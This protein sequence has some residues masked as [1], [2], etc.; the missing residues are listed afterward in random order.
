MKIAIIALLAALAG[1]TTLP[2]QAA[3]TSKEI[4]QPTDAVGTIRGTII[5]ETNGE[6]LIGVN[7]LVEGSATGTITDLD[8][9]FTLRLKPGAYNLNISYISYAS[10]TISEIMLS[11]DQVQV[12]DIRMK[13][14]TQL[15]S[16]V[17]VSARA[18]RNNE[19][20]LLTIQKKS[21]NLL[22]GISAQTFSRT[23]DSDV[24]S[25]VKRVTGV[26]VEDGKYVY[27]RGL[28]DR[29]SKSILNGMEIP[30]LDPER[31]T[32][33]LDIFPTN[34]IDNIIVYKSFTP[35]LPGDFTGGMVN[36]ETKDFPESRSI[37]IGASLGYDTETHFRDAFILYDGSKADA[38]A[39]GKK[40]RAL[41]FS[42]DYSPNRTDAATL[43]ANTN[44]LNKELD[45]AQK[46]NFLDQSYS[47]SAGN[48]I[49][50]GQARWGYFTALNY[51]NAYTFRPDVIRSE[52]RVVSSNNEAG[53][54]F[55]PLTE[56]SG[57]VGIQEVLWSAMASASVKKNN[58]S[59]SLKLFHT[60]SG[61]K[62]AAFYN[63]NDL[64]NTQ[65]AIESDLGYEQRMISNAL[66]SGEHL[67]AKK[68][69]LS[70]ANAFTYTSIDEPELNSS[71]FVIFDGDTLFSSGSSNVDK[72][73]R[74]LSEINNNTKFDYEM[75]FDSW[76]GGGAKFKAGASA[77]FKSRDYETYTVSIG[78]SD[79]FSPELTT[80][81]GGLNTILE[82]DNLYS[83]D[84][85]TGYLISNVQTDRENQY[86]SQLT[87]T[88]LYAMVELPLAAK[89]KFIGGLR[90]EYARM[91]YAGTERLS[92]QEIDQNVLNSWQ[93][94][95]AA[96]FVVNITDDMNLKSSYSRTLA[97]PSFREKSESI[98][99]DPVEGTT[100]YG[101]LNLVET[102]IHNA[103]LRWEYFF[104]RGEMVSV[105]GFYKKFINPIEV[106]P[107]ENAGANDIRPVNQDAADVYGFEV[108]F[109]KN[110]GFAHEKLTGLAIGSN[111]TWVRSRME[112]S[113]DQREKYLLVGA[114]VPAY[115]AMAGQSSYVVNASL[116]YSHDEAG[117]EVALSYNMKG[118]TLSLP[119]IGDIPDIYEASFHN[120]DLKFSQGLGKDKQARIS[121]SA[122][123]LLGDNQKHYY[124][125]LDEEAGI[126]RSYSKGRGITLGLSYAF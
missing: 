10:T 82:E 92:G 113:D 25:A 56:R 96:S 4:Q 30:G 91:N 19:N 65:L 6:P 53:Y 108:E 90:T 1:W 3:G 49:D 75:P 79:N 26:T 70:W 76:T 29:Y 95:P 41:P 16:E 46:N 83:P 73:F 126:Y 9:T 116:S 11:P 27:V 34:V 17:V 99:F 78:K 105:S 110:F 59:I 32:V 60:Q 106:Q 85:A 20:A 33:Q 5:D 114:E 57:K 125:F 107:L 120:L 15:I 21:A 54:T 74:E 43:F 52:I 72:L 67:V 13:P 111:F 40:S 104:G 94:L 88:G 80:I 50:K 86:S 71:E 42:K 22:D 121:L 18:L 31:N 89:F 101:N 66:L 119:G 62:S 124:E 36:V 39:L 103:D 47:F 100:Y 55:E 77:V 117:T 24:G 63:L 48:Q 37:R 98:I 58:N 102:N 51:K 97:R 93:F 7:I 45:A 112:L 8:G 109:R 28:G 38:F 12:L 35:D 23:G 115:R 2:G 61:E 118:A 44:S 123:N 122:K 84:N 68:H 87:V 69:K 14:E 81:S 64:F